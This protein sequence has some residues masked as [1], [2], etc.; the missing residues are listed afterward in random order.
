MFVFR[1]SMRFSVIFCIYEHIK[2]KK[3]CSG[4]S[5]EHIPKQIENMICVIVGANSGLGWLYRIEETKLVCAISRKL[6]FG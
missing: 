6:S 5:E 2:R 3:E 1:V 4:L